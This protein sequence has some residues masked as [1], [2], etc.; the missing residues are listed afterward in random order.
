MRIDF[1]FGLL[2]GLLP[3]GL[4]CQEGN[5]WYS[6][7]R[8][9]AGDTAYLFGDQ[10]RLRTGPG[11]NSETVTLLPI[12]SKVTIL[13]Q[14]DVQQTYQG[15]A[16][17]WYK[18]QY[19]GQA[20][21]VLGGLLA[22]DRVQHSGK[23]FLL[24]VALE[25]NQYYARCRSAVAGELKQEIRVELPAVS[26]SYP[27]FEFQVFDNRGLDGIEHILVIDS[28]PESCGA[29]GGATYLFYQ[30]GTLNKVF[31]TQSSSD[32]GVVWLHEALIFPNEENGVPGRVVYHRVYGEMMEEASNWVEET[33]VTREL[34]L[35]NGELV[36]KIRN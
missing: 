3:C 16:S 19:D 28:Y 1:F 22:A 21:Y 10:V 27:V 9:P 17:H 8:F 32:A 2:I 23:S 26:F 18:V 4:C 20:G 13:E 33:T 29:P 11:T 25:G 5:Y 14:T 30:N 35:V 36:P 6:D 7:H 31:Q 15:R 24:S 34:R 12:D